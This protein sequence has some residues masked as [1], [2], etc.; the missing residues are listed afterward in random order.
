M[1]NEFTREI[2]QKNI[3]KIQKLRIEIEKIRSR[4]KAIFEKLKNYDE[5]SN[6]SLKQINHFFYQN[7][8]N[9]YDHFSDDNSDDE[10][11]KDYEYDE[12]SQPQKKR[13][14]IKPSKSLK[15]SSRPSSN[16][17]TEKIN[18]RE[19]LDSETKTDQK[20]PELKKNNDLKTVKQN[21]ETKTSQHTDNESPSNHNVPTTQQYY[22]SF[23]LNELKNILHHNPS[24]AVQLLQPYMPYIKT[25]K[26]S[27]DNV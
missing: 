4:N 25:I 19:F 16:E 15:K 22:Q 7:N 24:L 14:K 5:W 20:S 21:Q 10:S 1:Q 26:R 18:I 11:D 2:S 9:K 17:L 6:N 27:K 23:T 3:Q 13:K 8:E 12:K